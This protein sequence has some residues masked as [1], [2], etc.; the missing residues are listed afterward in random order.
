MISGEESVE[1]IKKHLLLMWQNITFEYAQDNYHA[2]GKGAY[3]LR[4]CFSGNSVVI[5]QNESKK[6]YPSSHKNIT[7]ASTLVDAIATYDPA[8]QFVMGFD[9]ENKNV[10]KRLMYAFV[11]PL[12]QR[13]VKRDTFFKMIS[14]SKECYACNLKTDD[15]VHCEEC[16]CA[17]LCSNCKTSSRHENECHE[18]EYVNHFYKELDRVFT[19]FLMG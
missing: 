8:T 15:L 16:K 9:Y 10:K 18:T 12:L 4:V 5:Y 13:N 6:Y 17:L 1:N 14:K 7:S 2:S 11:L 3:I 19:T